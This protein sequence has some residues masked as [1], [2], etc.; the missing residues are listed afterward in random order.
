MM[1]LTPLGFSDAFPESEM[2]LEDVKRKLKLDFKVPSVDSPFE[3]R[4][5]RHF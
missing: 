1:R 3:F 5:V 2:T 4:S